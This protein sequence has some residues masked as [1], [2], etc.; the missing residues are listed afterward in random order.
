MT[1]SPQSASN[2]RS[3]VCVIC[4]GPIRLET[5]KTDE[6]G[7]AVH[8]DCYVHRTISRFRVANGNPATSGNWTSSRAEWPLLQY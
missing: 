1:G 4:A 2:H 7:R 5:S 6:R 3:N 8:E